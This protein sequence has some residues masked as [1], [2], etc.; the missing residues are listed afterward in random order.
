[1]HDELGS[2]RLESTLSLRRQ[3][4]VNVETVSHLALLHMI[5]R[6]CPLRREGVCGM[7]LMVVGRAAVVAAKLDLTLSVPRDVALP[8]GGLLCSVLICRTELQDST[9]RWRR[10]SACWV[11]WSAQM[12]RV[13]VMMAARSRSARLVRRSTHVGRWRG[14]IVVWQLIAVGMVRRGVG[15]VA[16]L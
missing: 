10:L 7:K 4:R 15:V 3:S 5:P 8:R 11:W 13:W 14:E 6:R 9:A 12:R 1:M 2:W 16:W